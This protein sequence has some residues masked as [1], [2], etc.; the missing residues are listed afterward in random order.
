MMLSIYIKK[1]KY[2]IIIKKNKIKIK[3]SFTF[4]TEYI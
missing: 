3:E 2:I 1:K 4:D